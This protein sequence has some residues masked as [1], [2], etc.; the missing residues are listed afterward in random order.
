MSAYIG[1]DYTPSGAGDTSNTS[2]HPE[3]SQS[4]VAITYASSTDPSGSW[5]LPEMVDHTDTGGSG[6]TFAGNGY[7]PIR[8]LAIDMPGWYQVCT[9]ASGWLDPVYG[10]N[11]SDLMWGCAGDG[12][13]I[14]AVR[15]YYETQDPNKTGW[16]VAEYNVNGLPNMHDLTDTGGSWDDYAGNGSRVTTFC[17]LSNRSRAVF[18]PRFVPAIAAAFDSAAVIRRN[19][20]SSRRFDSNLVIEQVL[21]DRHHHVF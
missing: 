8:W 13:P 21:R 7:D 19:S 6:D 3:Y 5:W 20:F 10:Y 2:W 11:K 18:V 17:C 16:L 4:D 1:G 9:E 15:C 14:T 12:S